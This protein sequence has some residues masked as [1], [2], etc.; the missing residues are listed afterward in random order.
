MYCSLISN[1]INLLKL[2]SVNYFNLFSHASC[3]YH[4]TSLLVVGNGENCMFYLLSNGNFK[5]LIPGLWL[6]SAFQINWTPFTLFNFQ[7]WQPNSTHFSQTQPIFFC[8]WQFGFIVLFRGK[9]KKKI[10][11]NPLLGCWN[12]VLQTGGEKQCVTEGE[13][14]S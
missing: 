14:R 4:I 11:T 7:L 3:K 9:K 10:W 5:L 1:Q 13:W 6:T 12:V 8:V 2:T